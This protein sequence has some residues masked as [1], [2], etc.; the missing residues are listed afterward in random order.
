MS[1]DMPDW[2]AEWK[3][4]DPEGYGV[5]MRA[6]MREIEISMLLLRRTCA[7]R[8]VDIPGYEESSQ[9]RP[10][11]IE[12]AADTDLSNEEIVVEVLALAELHT[13]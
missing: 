1:V 13:P 7:A 11:L 12:L 4:E 10:D 9:H 8:L 6:M 3:R 2:M 5:V